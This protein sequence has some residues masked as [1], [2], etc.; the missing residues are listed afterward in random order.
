[1]S[2]PTSV[3][4]VF[5]GYLWIGIAWLTVSVACVA[6][7]ELFMDDTIH[8]NYGRLVFYRTWG[9]TAVIGACL[10]AVSHRLGSRR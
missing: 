2:Q 3:R 4:K 9:P 7:A 10:T 5:R 1:M 6:V 8:G